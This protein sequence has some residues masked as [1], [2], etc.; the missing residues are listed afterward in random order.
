MRSYIKNI[1]YSFPIQLFI[2]HFRKYQIVLL[3][4]FLLFSTLAGG[5][6]KTFGADGLFFAPEY[7]N[8]VNFLS[9]LIVGCALGMLVM[10][11]NVTTFILHSKRFKFL[12][13]TSKPFLK[14]C[15]NNAV[16]PLLFIMF[17]FFKAYK[18]NTNNE[19][20]NNGEAWNM[21]GAT[22][23]GLILFLII[24]FAYFFGAD[25]TILWNIA[26]IIANK[27]RFIQAYNPEHKKPIDNFGLK[28][29]YY[30]STGMRLKKTRDV[31]HY[32][33]DFLDLLFKR[34]HI[35]AIFSIVLAFIF[36]GSIG[37]LLDN[38]F[39]QLPAAACIFAF[40]GVAIA[41]IGALTYFLQSWSLP[42]AIVLIFCLNILYQ[43]EII[44]PRN[45]AYGLNY[46]NKNERPNYTRKSLQDICTP[47][48]IEADKANMLTILNKWKAQ[49][50]EEKPLMVF[51]NVSGGGLRSSTFTMNTLQHLDSITHGE[52]MKKTVLISGASGGM[53]AAAYY[54]E[55]YNQ[56]LQN[57]IS[58]R[59]NAEYT[60]AIGQDLLNPI[61]SSMVSRDIFSPAQ[62]FNVGDYKYVKDRGYAF[63]QKL[64]AN[65]NSI[66]DKKISDYTI[67]EK[68]A[69]IPL[70][71]FNSTITNDGRSMLISSQPISFM[72]KP[73]EKN[74]DSTTID[75]VDFKALLAK[76]NPTNLRVLTALR[77]NATFPYV[78]PNVWL[79]TNPVIDVMDAGLNDNY[80]QNVSLRFI[81]NFKDW[82]AAN[83]SGVL[84]IQ[85]RD[86]PRDNWQQKTNANGDISDVVV[87]PMTML[88]HNWFKLQTNAQNNEYAFL[89]NNLDSNLQRLSFVYKPQKEDKGA[90]LSFH[91]TASEKQDIT[92]S[93]NNAVNQAAAQ[94]LK[95]LLRH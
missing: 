49:Q 78:L 88:Q 27:D 95:K 13:T 65:T 82:I 34:H 83:T 24:S 60:T 21:I 4:W 90:A 33:E 41:V 84:L 77:M 67:D 79:P 66:L 36:L 92:A 35:A 29:S 10:S 58:N 64:N 39:F 85:V 75:A 74:T 47:E 80:G 2:L 37:F 59:N 20:M 54:R 8:N 15:I 81:S 32:N 62:K 69:T 17:Y 16:L 22:L 68:N 42:F 9:G 23:L 89:Q 5:F 72:M 30:F 50:K 18:A 73:V 25:K 12:A 63:E 3:F 56:E 91:L 19:L 52:L 38:K 6:M 43:K 86:R 48:K 26:P 40:F 55:L 7:L 14:Y 71:F 87:K 70:L 94:Q 44:D 11:W 45:K 28:V 31:S 1:F 46:S 61:F 76:Q 53:L 51:I 93:F 57:K